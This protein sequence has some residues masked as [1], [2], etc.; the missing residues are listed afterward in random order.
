VAEGQDSNRYEMLVKIAKA[1]FSKHNKRK[2]HKNTY[3]QY[4]KQRRQLEF[5]KLSRSKVVR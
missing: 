4:A 5:L 3:E 1:T 2:G